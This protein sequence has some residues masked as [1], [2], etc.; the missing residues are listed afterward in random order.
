MITPEE[1]NILII[2]GTDESTVNITLLNLAAEGSNGVTALRQ[3]MIN[4][5]SAIVVLLIPAYMVDPDVVVE[6]VKAGAKAYIRKYASGEEIK[7]C[8]TKM[9]ER[10]GE[11]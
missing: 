11:K 5:P 9:L 2:E 1:T 7:R 6:A 4:D 10:S 3:L 8:L